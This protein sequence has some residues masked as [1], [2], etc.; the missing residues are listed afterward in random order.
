MPCKQH[1][2]FSGAMMPSLNNRHNKSTAGGETEREMVG[3]GGRRVRISEQDGSGIERWRCRNAE[4][5]RK[6]E[7]EKKCDKRI[8]KWFKMLLDSLH[9]CFPT[10]PGKLLAQHWLEK[11]GRN[12][13]GSRL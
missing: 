7:R 13:A 9:V 6:V 10:L 3:E 11:H 12:P 1:A 4:I 8:Q 5:W 2:A